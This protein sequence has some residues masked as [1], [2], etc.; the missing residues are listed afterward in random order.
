MKSTIKY[1]V[2][3]CALLVVG[4]G[5]MVLG[6]KLASAV[7]YDSTA[8]EQQ[9]LLKTVAHLDLSNRDDLELV[10]MDIT[11]DVAYYKYIKPEKNID[12]G[13]EVNVITGA[14]GVVTST[15]AVGF[16]FSTEDAI[17]AG[18]S[19]LAV[20]SNDVQVGYLSQRLPSGDYR[21]IWN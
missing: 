6:G 15:D 9:N 19:G 20:M 2:C 4:F 21:V 5:L 14:T 18:D 3:A 16:T 17:T 12:I 13:S 1:A 11:Q 8:V 10:A 7:A